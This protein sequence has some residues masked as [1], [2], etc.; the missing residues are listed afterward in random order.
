MSNQTAFCSVCDHQIVP[1]VACDGQP[2]ECPAHVYHYKQARKIGNYAVTID[3][4]TG[5]KERVAV[6]GID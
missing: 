3:N 6:K 2:G 1:G 4:V 5:C